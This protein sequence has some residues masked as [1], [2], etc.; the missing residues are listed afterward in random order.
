M[1]M[2]N[3]FL[4]LGI[5]L[6]MAIATQAQAA[7]D[8]SGVWG[9]DDDAF[10]KNPES[11]WSA[12]KLPFTPM[13]RAAFEANHPG[14]GPRLFK[15]PQER[16]DPIT[17]GN[18]AGLM[19]TLIYYY[20]SPIEFVQA[21]GRLIQTF[22]LGRVWRP[23]YLDGRPVPKDMPAGPYW[24]GHSVGHWEG[25]TL[26]VNTMALDSRAWLDEWGTPFSDDARIE[27]RWRRVSPERLE[28]KITVTDP[29]MYTK[30]WTSIPVNMKLRKKGAE[31]LETIHAP[32]D[33]A[34]FDN[35]VAHPAGGT[36][37]AK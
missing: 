35:L 17:L 1:K 28:L 33:E 5:A 15:N 21:P 32:V 25:D 27:E 11:E 6:V 31:L 9:R 36:S 10:K 20:L 24:Y 8:L 13:G 3:H 34:V 14:K 19:R 23:I 12:E 26:V 7:A 16:N 29:A 4:G 37:S 18:P 2:R 22:E 30:P